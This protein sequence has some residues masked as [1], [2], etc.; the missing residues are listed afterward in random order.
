VDT[1]RCFLNTGTSGQCS[2]FANGEMAAIDHSYLLS[3]IV[4]PCPTS[5]ATCVTTPQFKPGL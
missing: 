4:R 5:P 1:Q 3:S 2:F